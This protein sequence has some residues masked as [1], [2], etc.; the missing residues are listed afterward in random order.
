MTW[1]NEYLLHPGKTRTEKSEDY[2]MACVD[3]VDLYTIRIPSKTQ[4]QKLNTGWFKI[5]EVTKKSVTPVQD[6]S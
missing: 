2:D 6:F 4:I 3:L 5:V 1:Y